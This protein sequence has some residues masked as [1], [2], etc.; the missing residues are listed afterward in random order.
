LAPA[1]GQNGDYYQ[2]RDT[3]G[4]GNL[5]VH[6]CPPHFGTPSCTRKTR[7]EFVKWC[8]KERKETHTL[9]G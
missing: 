9:L 7:I 5:A 4:G 2:W 8:V 6:G 1:A 3:V